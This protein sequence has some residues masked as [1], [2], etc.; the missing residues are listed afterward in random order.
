MLYTHK[1]NDFFGTTIAQRHVLLDL[2]EKKESTV[3]EIAKEL[4]INKGNISKTIQQLVEMGHVNRVISQDDRRF[5]KITLTEKGQVLYKK[6]S[7]TVEAYYKNIFKLIPEEK[8]AAIV[9]SM[10]LFTEAIVK[11]DSERQLLR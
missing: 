11:Y 1:V 5:T 7:R 2:G 9:E 6:I 10:G 4:S 3:G 8:Q